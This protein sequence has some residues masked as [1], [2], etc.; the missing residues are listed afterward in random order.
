MDEDEVIDELLDSLEVDSTG[1]SRDAIDASSIGA[2]LHET[3]QLAEDVPVPI[4]GTHTEESLDIEEFFDIDDLG[5]GEAIQIAPP[6]PTILEPIP[7]LIPVNSESLSVDVVTSR[8]SSAEWYEEIQKAEVMLAGVGGIGSYVAFLLSR[9]NIQQLVLFDNDIVEEGN[10]SGQLFSIQDINSSKVGAIAN[11][12]RIYSKFHKIYTYNDRYTVDN[13][14]KNIMICGFDNMQARKVYFTNWLKHVKRLKGNE[15]ANALFIDGRLAAE[16]Y[17]ILC[18]QGNDDYSINKYTN[19]Y[20]F[21]D[22]E[23]DP[24]IC[25]YKQTTFM[26]NHIASTMVNLFV[27]FIANKCNPIIDRTLP[28]LTEYNASTMYFKTVD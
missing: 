7:D 16:E 15:K 27:N 21:S 2:Y 1:T 22:E 8:F 4:T 11:M 18:I 12:I 20:L 9:L 26:A 23:A 17:Q 24:T 25:S 14:A 28:F 13:S 5:S 19:E 10:L 3:N 6:V